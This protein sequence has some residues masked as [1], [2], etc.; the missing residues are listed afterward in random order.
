MTIP[1]IAVQEFGQSIWLDYIHRKELASGEFQRKIDEEGILGVTSNPSIFQKS[2]GESD[3]YDEAIKSLLDLNAE[4]VYE[5]LAIQDIQQAAD[6]FRPVYDRTNKKDGYVSLEVSPLIA[7]DTDKTISEA[8]RLFEAVNRPNLMI[9]IPA[10][11]AG[12]PAIEESIAAGINV[13]VTLIFAINNYEEVAEAFIR[14]L[15][16]RKEAGEDISHIASVASFFL[17]RIDVMVDRILENNIR[18]A[19]VHGDTSRMSANR[20]LLGQTAIANAKIAYRSFQKIFESQRFSTL[21]EAGAQ[22]QRPLWASTGT[23]NPAYPDTMYIDMLIGEDTVNT[24]PPKTLTAFLAHGTAASTLTK[25][26]DDFLNPKD[27]MDKLAELGIDLE[28]ITQRLQVDGVEA[29]IESFETLLDQVAAKV[30]ILRTG[31]AARQKLAL[32]IYSD[33]FHETIE[34]IDRD[35]VNSRIWSKDGSVWKTHTPT[36]QKIR[37]RLGWLDVFKTID[38]QR[39]KAF[40]EE[41]K[42]GDVTHVVLLGMGS[43]SFAP[44]VMHHTFGQQPDFPEMIVLDSTDPACIKQVEDQINPDKTLFIV[45]TK[46]GTTVETRAFYSYFFKRVGEQGDQFIAITDEGTW[47]ATEAKEKNF[48]DIYLNP[49]DINGRYGALSYFGMVPAAAMGLDLDRFWKSAETMAEACSQA[50]KA[51]FHPGITLG[52]VLGALGKQ[53]RNKV[54]IHTTQSF[55]TFGVWVEQLI[56]ES[57]GKDRRGLVPV[58]ESTVGMPHDYSSDRV[59]IYLRVDD[60]PDVDQMDERIRTI[61]EAGHPRMTV[62]LPDIYAMGGEFF[63]WEFATAIA[64]AIYNVNPFD[65]PNINESKETTDRLLK[66]YAETGEVKQPQPS[67]EQDGIRF[68]ADETTMTPL[69]ELCAAHGYDSESMHQLLGAQ[70]A[71]THAGDYFGLL[72]YYTPDEEQEKELLD[73]QRRLRH[74]TMRAITIG[75][76]PR[77][78]HSTGQLHKGGPNDGIFLQLT[79]DDPVELEIPDAGYSFS[80][81]FTAQAAGDMEMLQKHKRRVIRL[82][83]ADPKAIID[84]IV[85]AV[86]FVEQRKM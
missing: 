67:M 38:R 50:V 44:Y 7:N 1:P 32:G 51:A 16:R 72:V 29:F 8:K 80:T 15:E 57:L 18:Q 59:F 23:K 48:H 4:A 31:I 54:S 73:I 41:V 11:T 22:V 62:R 33:E 56:A 43:S 34:Q 65:E 86:N 5:T 70:L 30:T 19:Q 45:S 76:G 9:K 3:V 42:S 66:T 2:I 47:L 46:S 81:L 27:V 55:K 61:R 13:N 85:Q 40:Q 14:G 6:L 35:F 53:G 79:L 52:A 17:S 60:D 63:R 71:A 37:Q 74:V 49:S 64:G 26:A 20:K 78:L 69:R 28:Q 82:H 75:Y 83:A 12:I 25:D 58:V 84:K 39:L 36:I 10:T 77:Y 24:V 21:K 68:Y